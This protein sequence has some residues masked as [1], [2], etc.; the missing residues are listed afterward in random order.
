MNLRKALPNQ[1]DESIY[2][3]SRPYFLAFLPWFGLGVL[4]VL[5]GII[6]AVVSWNIFPEIRFDPL[7]HNLFVILTSA[8]FLLLV[9]FMTVAFIDFYYDLHIVTD[10][11]VMDIDQN[12]LFSR[13][14]STLSLDEVQDATARNRGILSSVFNF[15]DVI[16]QSS[17]S[18]Q[19][20]EFNDVLH[21]N[22]IATIILDL[23]DQAKHRVETGEATI[24][25]QGQLKGVVNNDVFR[26]IDPLKELGAFAEEKMPDI[27]KLQSEKEA[28]PAEAQAEPAEKVEEPKPEEA[29]KPAPE[30]KPAKPAKAEEPKKPAKPEPTPAPESSED[31][32][33]VIDEP[34]PKK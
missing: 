28:K 31:L 5:M 22:E 12:S 8:Y 14:V 16:I 29:E 18:Q 20:F 4:L 24:M 34:E 23:A 6:F 9:P 19:F 33:I 2:V 15:G 7:A 27:E 11:R 21:P 32:D 13:E 17:G 3:F 30:E 26:S 25:P 1:T 10:R